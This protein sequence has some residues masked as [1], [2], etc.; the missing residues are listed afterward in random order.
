MVREV[1]SYHLPQP[2]DLL[3]YRFMHSPS[4]RTL[5]DVVFQRSDPERPMPIA[6]GYELPPQSQRPIGAAVNARMQIHESSFQVV[7]IL[8]NRPVW[9][10][11]PG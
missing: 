11:L 7:L 6:F 1:C 10:A 8:R 3:R 9:A 5:D 4:H 2:T